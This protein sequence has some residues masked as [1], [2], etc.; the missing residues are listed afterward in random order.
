MS[1]GRNFNK[2][3]PKMYCMRIISTDTYELFKLSQRPLHFFVT[4]NTQNK[5]YCIFSSLKDNIN[6]VTEKTGF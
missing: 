3:L 5:N 2:H 6:H 1:F 4:Y